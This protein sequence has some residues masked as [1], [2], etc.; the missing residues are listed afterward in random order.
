MYVIWRW[1]HEILVILSYILEKTTLYPKTYH[2]VDSDAIAKQA[3]LEGSVEPTSTSVNLRLV[4]TIVD[5]AR[6]KSMDTSASVFPG[7]RGWI[8]R[9]SSTLAVTALALGSVILVSFWA[10]S[11]WPGLII[12]VKMIWRE[13]LVYRS[14]VRIEERVF[15][16]IR[17]IKN[18]FVIVKRVTPGYK[19]VFENV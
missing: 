19:E 2:Q 8:V 12:N 9:W 13:M 4:T 7:I 14:L 18:L 17:K 10:R 11:V 3:S 1:I 6:T 5:A 16:R 15:I